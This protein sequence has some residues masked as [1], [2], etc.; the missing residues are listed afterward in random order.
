M[1]RAARPAG[2]PAWQAKSLLYGAWALLIALP[3]FGAVTGTVVNRT[4]GAPQAGAAVGLDR[5]G[6][7]G[8]EPVAETKADAQG[9]FSIAQDTAGQAPFLLRA[10]YDGVRYYHVLPPGTPASGITLDVYVASKKP[11]EAKVPKHMILFQHRRQ[12]A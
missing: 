2:K 9:R 1:R 3:A 8:P 11:G 6:Q 10:D 7:N 4:T 12:E 5:L